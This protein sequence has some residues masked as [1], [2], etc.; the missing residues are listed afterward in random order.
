MPIVDA[1]Y[2]PSLQC[3]KIVYITNPERAMN[4]QKLIKNTITLF[5]SPEKFYQ[6]CRY[7]ISAKLSGH[8]GVSL[9]GGG[10]MMTSSFNEH[11]SAY[12]LMPSAAEINMMK[13]RVTESSVIFDIG[14]NVGVWTVMMSKICNAAHIHSFEPAPIT[15]DLLQKNVNLNECRNVMLNN[16]AASNSSGVAEFEVPPGVSIYG[17][18]RPKK[19]SDEVDQRFL[20]PNIY[21]VKCKRLSDYCLEH[22]I[23]KIDFMKIDVEGFELDVLMGMEELF[24]EHKIGAIYIETM[25]DNHLRMGSSYR[26][27]LD[28]FG[29]FDYKIY[30]LGNDGSALS[31]RQPDQVVEHN[32][33]CIPS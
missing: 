29:R 26:E 25:E 11:W 18:V 1:Y 16:M 24:A 30:T 9:P 13:Q 31:E 19:Q 12:T 3:I 27:F 20:N 4:I 15:F 8:G 5:S 23:E 32:H 2:S 21:E 22:N 28:F 14:A 6:Y 7:L 33:L 17:R 10:K